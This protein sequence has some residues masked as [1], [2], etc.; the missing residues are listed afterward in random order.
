[1]KHCVYE[2]V[3]NITACVSVGKDQG[4]RPAWKEKGGA[5]E[6]AGGS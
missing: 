6:T 4:Q 5:V 2:C 3:M 1:M